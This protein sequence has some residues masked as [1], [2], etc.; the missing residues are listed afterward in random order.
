MGEKIKDI[1][2]VPNRNC[3][4]CRKPNAGFTQRQTVLNLSET[5]PCFHLDCLQKHHKVGTKEKPPKNFE[6]TYEE[7]HEENLIPVDQL[8]YQVANVR[9]LINT[10]RQGASQAMVL[11]TAESDNDQTDNDDAGN[12][13]DNG[14][15]VFEDESGN[16]SDDDIDNDQ[17]QGDNNIDNVEGNVLED[18]QDQGQDSQN[19]IEPEDQSL[20]TF[21]GHKDSVNSICYIPGKNQIVSASSDKT[22]KLWSLDDEECKQTFRGHKDSVFAVCYLPDKNQIVSASY[23]KTLKLWSLENGTCVKTFE[24]HTRSISSVCY[25]PDKN[26]IGSASSDKTLKLWALPEVDQSNN[27]NMVLDNNKDQTNSNTDQNGPEDNQA[28]SSNKQTDSSNRPEDNQTGSS[29]KQTDRNNNQTGNVAKNIVYF[30]NLKKRSSPTGKQETPEAKR[31]KRYH[32]RAL[33]TLR[34]MVND[35]V[36][37]SIDNIGKTNVEERFRGITKYP[38][39]LQT[40]TGQKKIE[41]LETHQMYINIWENE[42]KKLKEKPSKSNV[43]EYKLDVLEKEIKHS[44]KTIDFVKKGK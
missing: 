28:D 41:I 9:E 25:I 14:G 32:E 13:N 15:N 20:L 36:N 22:L 24:G 12:G 30:K 2:E 8:Y 6:Y 16:A 11:E 5:I 39:Y 35:M 10:R 26:Q 43:D 3:A 29:K 34:C 38:E 40:V 37:D 7:V 4:I 44:L 19:E 23:D 1:V 27:D 33:K 31:Q 21:T 18:T 17:S 42:I